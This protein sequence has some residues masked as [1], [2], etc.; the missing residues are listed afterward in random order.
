MGET[1]RLLR[2]L[3]FQD[4]L[5]RNKE[6]IQKT[7]GFINGAGIAHNQNSLYY[8]VDIVKEK[9]NN[10]DLYPDIS[11]KAALYTYNIITRHIFIDGNKRTGMICAFLFLRIN[12]YVIKELLS[13]DEIV[14]VAIE[15]S[16]GTMSLTE[17]T[18][19]FEEKVIEKDQ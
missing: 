10:N 3:S 15:I 1:S 18:V 17:L 5:I 2:Y 6:I 7:G 9:I 12:G 8:L 19:W 14:D 11:Q 4:I 16:K 13:D